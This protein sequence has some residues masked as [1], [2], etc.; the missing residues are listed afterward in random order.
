MTHVTKNKSFAVLQRSFLL[1]SCK[2]PK[3]YQSCQYQHGIHTYF[4]N[5]WLLS[6]YSVNPPSTVRVCPVIKQALSPAK[7]ATTSATSST[8]PTRPS[9]VSSQIACTSSRVRFLFILV[10]ISPGATQFTRIPE[11]HTSFASAFAKVIC[12]PLQAE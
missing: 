5:V 6:H 8:L 7:K 2:I 12:A 10:S 11:G 4:Q 1:L 9:G 3:Q